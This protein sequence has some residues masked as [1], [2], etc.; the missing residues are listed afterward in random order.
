MNNINLSVSNWNQNIPKKYLC[1]KYGFNQSPSVKWTSVI[2]SK[3]YAFILQDLNEVSHN[4]IHW[5]IPSI[6]PSIHSISTLKNNLNPKSNS[7]DLLTFYENNPQIPLKQGLNT[8]SS[9][10]YHGPCAPKNT[11]DHE[12]V[13][14]FYA[15][16]NDIFKV[17]NEKK[18]QFA[19][20]YTNLFKPKTK[21][22]FDNLLQSLGIK[23]IEFTTHSG[24]FNPS[25][26]IDNDNDNNNNNDNDNESQSDSSDS[27][28][29][30]NSFSDDSDDDDDDDEDED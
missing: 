11:G 12:Y 10:G 22:E 2:N 20:E 16:D 6:D 23:T 3:S 4:F 9:F 28:S 14:Y 24:F 17:L 21:S 15:L 7:S 1:N 13:F 30:Y 18:N 5:Y 26:L 8:S 25:S 29:D 27:V 19:N